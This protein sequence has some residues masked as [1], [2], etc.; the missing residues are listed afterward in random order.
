MT[1]FHQYT[2]PVTA[3]HRRQFFA[4]LV[5]GILAL[6]PLLVLPWLNTSA[7]ISD[8]DKLDAWPQQAAALGLVLQNQ[9]EEEEGLYVL[10]VMESSAAQTMGVEAGDLLLSLD[11]IALSSC[12]E[13]DA[14]LSASPNA[15]SLTFTLLRDGQELTLDLSSPQG[16]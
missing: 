12:D 14:L 2:P 3:I 8:V 9:S 16:T 10:A 4:C 11:G 7:A 15:S 1:H 13:L 6:S 5:L